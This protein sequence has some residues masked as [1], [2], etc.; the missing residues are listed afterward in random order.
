MVG[1]AGQVAGHVGQ[2]DDRP[3][4]D[5]HEPVVDPVDAG[6][7]D[8]RPPVDLPVGAEVVAEDAVGADRRHPQLVVDDAQRLGELLADGPA[9]DAVEAQHVAEVLGADHGPPRPVQRPDRPGGVHADGT[10]AVPA[11]SGAAATA[12]DSGPVVWT[13]GRAATAYQRVRPASTWVSA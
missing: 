7:V 12:A 13:S 4:A 11:A 9:A 3:Q 2:L 1:V 5:R 6:E 8:H 10:A